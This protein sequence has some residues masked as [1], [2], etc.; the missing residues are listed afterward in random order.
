M[1]SLLSA[2]TACFHYGSDGERCCARCLDPALFRCATHLYEYQQT[3][4][5]QLLQDAAESIV[6]CTRFTDEGL[7][8]LACTGIHSWKRLCNAVSALGFHGYQD[9]GELLTALVSS[10]ESIRG[11]WR[12]LD[13]SVTRKGNPFERLVT[14]LYLEELAPF[15]RRP[16]APDDP[17]PS[18]RV[19]WNRKLPSLAGGRR[20]IDVL[21]RWRHQERVADTIVECRDHEVKVS[22]VDAFATLVRRV[23][24]DRGVMVSSVGFQSGAERSAKLDEIETRVVSEEDFAPETVERVVDS[25]CS[26]EIIGSRLDSADDG[27]PVSLSGTPEHRIDVLQRGVVRGTLA[28]LMAEAVTRMAPELGAMPPHIEYPTPDVRVLFP[29]GRS[30]GIKALHLLLRIVEQPK[31]CTLVVPRRPLAFTVKSSRPMLRK[32]LASSVP[33]FPDPSF[34]GERFYVNLMGQAYYCERTDSAANEASIVLLND[35]QHGGQRIDVEARVT[36]DQA[37]HY[38]LVEDKDAIKVLKQDLARFQ[39]FRAR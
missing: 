13:S 29:D 28:Q 25:I 21:L 12:D 10:I 31:R 16:S 9:D 11:P 34:E 36:L 23:Q 19:L 17:G 32:V 20:Q 22:E 18:V 26:F 39:G 37:T 7:P 30:A 6:Q 35:K 27:K 4:P 3:P 33:L 1:P 15:T 14:R 2:S 5:N 8:R 24:A 38:Y